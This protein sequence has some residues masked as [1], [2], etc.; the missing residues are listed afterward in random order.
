MID[1]QDIVFRWA[2]HQSQSTSLALF[3]AGL[4]FLLQGFRFA[5]FLLALTCGGGGYMIAYAVATAMRVPPFP[6]AACVGGFLG[7]LA[8][9]QFRL[10]IVV[11]STFVFA[12]LAHFLTSKFT[13][14]PTTVLVADGLGAALGL[15]L[16]WICYRNLPII[17]TTIQGTA[18]LLVAFVGITADLAPSLAATFVE[19]GSKIPLMMPMFMVMLFV[20]GYSVQANMQQGDMLTGAGKGWN[21]AEAA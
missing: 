21:S 15:S 11:S 6:V 3:V 20:L 5:R 16:K 19:W 1:L 18:I 4:L 8:M 2:S 7:A 12:I 17:S 13:N 14:N 9:I 10:G